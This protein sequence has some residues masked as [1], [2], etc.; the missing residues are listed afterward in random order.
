MKSCIGFDIGN[1]SVHVAVAKNGCVVRGESFR[2]D[3]DFVKNGVITSYDAMA[4]KLGQLRRD[5]KFGTRNAALVLPSAL[6]YCRRF[7]V[8]AKTREQ[9]MFNIPYGFRDF[10]TDDKSHYFFDG[11]ILG[12]VKGEENCPPELDVFATAARKDVIEQYVGMFAKA[13]FKLRTVIPREFALRNLLLQAGGEPHHHGILDI[14]QSAVR[15]YLFD[16][17]LFEGVRVI[18]YGMGA[19]D[20]A[21]SQELGVDAFTA[22]A[23]R[24]NDRDGANELDACKSIYS[25]IAL[26]VLK[27]TN[28]YR[29]NGGISL[30]HLHCC[31]GGT[32]SAALIKTLKDTLP[33]PLLDMSELFDKDKT[34]A[35]VDCALVAAAAGVAIQ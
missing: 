13:G 18:D 25:D 17:S 35:S 1:R 4:D 2:L 7:F 3:S 5:N 20:S 19:I 11:A 27:A 8:A 16:G 14:G 12:A 31:G 24:E 22:A 21:I 15:L 33:L 23:M 10:I 26:E 34:D 30:E 32:H 9:L 28:F 29:F 6:C